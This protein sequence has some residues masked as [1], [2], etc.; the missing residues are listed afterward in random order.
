[1]LGWVY[2]SHSEILWLLSRARESPVDRPSNLA[3]DTERKRGRVGVGERRK[4]VM[5]DGDVAQTSSTLSL[6][7]LQLQRVNDDERPTPTPRLIGG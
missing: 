6:L 2:D 5:G 3:N 1:M 4:I 7:S